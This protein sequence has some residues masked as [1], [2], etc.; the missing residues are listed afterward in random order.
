MSHI[1]K[2]IKK[3]N[4]HI[5]SERYIDIQMMHGKNNKKHILFKVIEATSTRD[6]EK[7]NKTKQKSINL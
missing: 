1:A 4:N 6:A 3:E 7:Q 5:N 2:E